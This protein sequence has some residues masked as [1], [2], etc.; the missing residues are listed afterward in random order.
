MRRVLQTLTYIHDRD[1]S[2]VPV[3]LPIVIMP[4]RGATGADAGFGAGII[5]HGDGYQQ[6]ENMQKVGERREK[7][8]MR[9][10][11]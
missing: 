4:Q 3:H 11:G 10:R 2:T 7:I 8:T 1:K 5:K 9:G 6:A